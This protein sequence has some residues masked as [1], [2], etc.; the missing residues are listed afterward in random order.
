MEKWL[1]DKSEEILK[2]FGLKKGQIILDF[3]CGS[4][5]Y[6]IIASNI[7]GPKGKVYAL[8]SDEEGLLK[9]LKKKIKSQKITNIEI[10]KTSGEISIPLK[11]NYI[12]FFLLF[13]VYHLL[14]DEERDQVLKEAYRVL[15]INGMLSYHATHVGSYDIDLEKVEKRMNEFGFKLERKFQKPMFHWAWI[16]DSLVFNYKKI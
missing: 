6:S 7:V 3:G 15:N 5:I 14:N 11:D 10:I 2:E 12:D 13:D 4:G 16:E 9:K 1:K 8:D